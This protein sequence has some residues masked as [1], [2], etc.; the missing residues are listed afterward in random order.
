MRKTSFTFQNC[1][2][3]IQK[4]NIDYGIEKNGSISLVDFNFIITRVTE[5]IH[6]NFLQQFVKSLIDTGCIEL[7]QNKNVVTILKNAEDLK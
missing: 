7:N 2:D 3:V 6:P 5:K 1:V 4:V